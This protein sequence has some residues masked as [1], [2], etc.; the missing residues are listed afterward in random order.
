MRFHVAAQE[1]LNVRAEQ[2][3]QGTHQQVLVEGRCQTEAVWCLPDGDHVVRGAESSLYLPNQ[4]P[5]ARSPQQHEAVWCLPDGN[6]VV[7][8]AESC[9]YLP[10]EKPLGRSPQQHSCQDRQVKIF[11]LP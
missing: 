10:K 1:H 8:R 7:R 6:Q 3:R 9:L 5:L 11:E 2:R 4:K